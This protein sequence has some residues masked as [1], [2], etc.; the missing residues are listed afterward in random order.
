VT[1][2]IK[3]MKLT[4]AA[5][6]L[7]VMKYAKL[8]GWRTAH[9]RTARTTKGWRTAVQGD[10]KGFPDLVMVRGSRMIVAELKVGDNKLT[11]EQHEWILSFNEVFGFL[12]DQRT[13]VW[14]PS[15]WPEIEKVL[16]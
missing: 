11:S 2:R 6:L 9:F 3:T 8:R 16:A 4:E 12:H 5:F 10:G 1:C 14:R 7:Q 13:Y 15:D